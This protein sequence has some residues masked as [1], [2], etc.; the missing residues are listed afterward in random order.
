MTRTI[1]SGPSA[2]RVAR[3][4]LLIAIAMMAAA[5]G[6]AA[7]AEAGCKSLFGH[8]ASQAVMNFD[9]TD[10]NAC[11]S[12]VGFCT[13]GK[14][15]GGLQG[16]FR[17]TLEELIPATFDPETGEPRVSFFVG[18]SRITIKN[19]GEQLI[20]TDTGALDFI[21]GQIATLLTFTGGTGAF[22]GASGHI[23][24]SGVAD[25]ATGVNIGDFR[26]EV[27]TPGP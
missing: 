7:E 25:F 12:P 14:V 8:F 26:G 27:C 13:D 15:I 11:T 4:A 18:E 24:I 16:T 20:G 6:G 21:E 19:T 23:V 22:D 9:P 10:P 1:N 3:R 17:L 2:F 5:V